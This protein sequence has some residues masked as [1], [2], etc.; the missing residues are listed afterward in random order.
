MTSNSV[1]HRA[2]RYA[3]YANAAAASVGFPALAVA[4]APPA[5]QEAAQPVAEVVVTG[6]RIVEPGLQAISPVTSVTQD[7]IKSQGV[8][9]I[10]DMINNLPQVVADQGSMASN[11]ASGTATVDLRGLGP[12]RTL[13]LINGRRLVPGT[14]S[15]SPAFAAQDLNNIPAALVERVDVLTGGASAVYGADATAGVV[16]FIMN[17]HFQGFRIDA[18]ADM[19]NHSQHNYFG[20]FAPASGDGSA[21]GTVND[22]KTK[23][24]TFILGG[25][26]ADGKGNVTAYVGYRR[27]DALTQAERDFSRCSLDTAGGKVVC[28]GSSTA[29]TGRLFGFGTA[30]AAGPPPVFGVPFQ[31]FTGFPTPAFGSGATVNTKTGQLVPWMDSDAFNYGAL[32]YYQRPD[33]RWTAGAFAH[34]NWD[35]H[36]EMYTEFMLMSDHTLAQIAPSGMF[37]GSGGGVIP[38]GYANAGAPDGLWETNC[39]NPFLSAQEVNTLCGGSTAAGNVELLMGRRNVEGGNRIDDLTHT[40]FRLVVGSKGELTDMLSYDVYAMEGITQLSEEYQNDVSLARLTNAL[41]VGGTLANPVCLAN[42]NGGNGAPGCVPYNIW[43]TG[44]VNPAAVKYFTVPGFQEG[45]NEERVVSGN[46]TADLTKAGVKLPAAT[47]GLIVNVGAEYREEIEDLR[48]DAE[49][50]GNGARADLNGQGSATL[51][52]SAGMHVSEGFMEARLPLVQDRPGAKELSLE[53]G[54][55]YSSYTLGFNTNT[56]KLGVDWAPLSDLRLRASYNRAVRVPNLQELFAQ[57]FIGLDGSTDPCTTTGF[58]SP[59]TAKA[60]QC[61]TRPPP[62]GVTKAQYGEPGN[63]AGQYNGQIGGNPTLQPE[64]ADTYT[65]GIVLTPTALPS[66]SMTLDYFDIKINH[67]ITSYG[68]NFIINQC[69]LA[70]NPVF[71]S[72]VQQGQNVGV[73]R[74]VLGSTWFSINGYVEDPLLNLGY[75]LDKGVDVGAH[76]RQDMGKLGHMDFALAGTYTATA[77]TEPYSGSGTYDCAGYYGATCLNPLPKWRHVFSDTWATPLQGFDVMARWRHLNS[78]KLETTNASPLLAGTIN[79]AIAS[80]GSRDYLDLMLMYQWT[81]GI[82]TRLGVNNVLDKDPPI[83]PTTTALPPP[84][85]NGNTYPQVYDTLG[86]YIFLNVT[87]DY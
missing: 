12:Q 50:I 26:F 71:C 24:I 1:L 45:E 59:P 23:D 16:N 30:V 54:Y 76:Y 37:L 33:E 17:D 34:Y 70:N 41:L 64:I 29:A 8:T 65:F 40:S 63:P 22:G 39:S 21:P 57:K 25:N 61:T 4:Q 72:S 82:T 15:N 10:E 38:A 86:R 52:L 47:T 49:F 75:Y 44:R 43:G 60:A 51:P 27:I 73:H 74:D 66:F 48:P 80:L 20:Q 36:H 3:L 11:G 85:F 78:T 68:A 31:F 53:A 42:A 77:I 18:N 2:V 62:V 67:V 81:K 6:S 69:V 35:E 19:Y 9:R 84:F 55:R 56:Y 5:E 7:E 13:V 28:G 32:N 83:L 79:P 58:G 87:I 46:I 14:P